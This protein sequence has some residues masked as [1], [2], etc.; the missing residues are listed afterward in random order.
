MLLRILPQKLVIDESQLT[1]LVHDDMFFYS[2][3]FPMLFSLS[4]FVELPEWVA[5]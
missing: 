1:G 2:D 3:R 5:Q 4:F